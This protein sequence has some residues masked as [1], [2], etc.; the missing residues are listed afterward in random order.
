MPREPFA[1]PRR[2]VKWDMSMPSDAIRLLMCV[3]LPPTGLIPS[4]C[5]T[6]LTD[7]DAATDSRK[8]F[9]EYRTHF[10]GKWEV[11]MFAAVSFSRR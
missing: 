4:R 2:I 6:S 7:A 9:S 5:K 3:W 1:R 11:S 10:F 8:D